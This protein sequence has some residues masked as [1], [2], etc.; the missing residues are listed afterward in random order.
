MSSTP[1][2]RPMSQSWR[3]GAAGE[4]HPAVAHDERGDPVP[5]G[6]AQHRIPGDLAV[7]V[8]V[9]VDDSRHDEH[10]RG[11]DLLVAVALDRA[12]LADRPAV[13][14]DVGGSAIGAVPSTTVPLRMTRSG[15]GR[16]RAKPN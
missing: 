7:V 13:D 2:I 4:P 6:G 10:A 1:S 9:D 8:G 3:S 11:V 15:M 5:A 14:G 16:S 12:H